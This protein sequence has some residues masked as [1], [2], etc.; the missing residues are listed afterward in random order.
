MVPSAARREREKRIE[1]EESHRTR[2]AN[3][4]PADLEGAGYSPS[5]SKYQK[6]RAESEEHREASGN[7]QWL[8]PKPDQGRI[9]EDQIRQ[10][11]Q[12]IIAIRLK[13][14]AGE[15]DRWGNEL[16]LVVI[17][18]APH[19]AAEQ[20]ASNKCEEN[21]QAANHAN[22]REPSRRFRLAVHALAAGL[23]K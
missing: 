1:D 6:C 5:L 12:W 15:Q 19:R 22:S 10:M 16:V 18:V 20:Y 3:E 23:C 11:K 8:I 2:G 13:P 4:F 21:N 17:Q 14:F 9:D 7:H